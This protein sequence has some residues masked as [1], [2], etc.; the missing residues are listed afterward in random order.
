[1]DNGLWFSIL[2]SFVH[3]EFILSGQAIRKSEIFLKLWFHWFSWLQHRMLASELWC[4]LSTSV[5]V[6]TIKSSIHINVVICGTRLLATHP[7]FTY[8]VWVNIDQSLTTFYWCLGLFFIN[9]VEYRF[10]GSEVLQQWRNLTGTISLKQMWAWRISIW[11]TQL[12]DETVLSCWV[13][14]VL[15]CLRFQRG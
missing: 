15:T 4:V 12:N 14:G 3:F 6:I 9:M 1:M 5:S 11:T 13:S 7:C 8:T 2:C 10:Y